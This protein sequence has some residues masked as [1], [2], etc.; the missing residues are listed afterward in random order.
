M[1]AKLDA[2][3]SSDRFSD[4]LYDH[5]RNP[6]NS[7]GLA[8]PSM[9]KSSEETSCGDE[10]EFHVDIAADG[11]IDELAFESRSCAVSRAVA[12]LITEYPEGT[13]QP[14]SP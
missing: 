5:H 7:G 8:N 10:G 3:L 14:A 9:V 6:R 11:T 1:D 2:Y 4:R 12:S 13:E